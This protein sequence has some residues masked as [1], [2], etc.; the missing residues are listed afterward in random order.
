MVVDLISVMT[1]QPT[2]SFDCQLG[3]I[4]LPKSVA[5]HLDTAR[6]VREQ[7]ARSQHG[8]EEAR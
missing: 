2:A 8:A 5:G 4:E 3:A 6:Q 1:D 7:A